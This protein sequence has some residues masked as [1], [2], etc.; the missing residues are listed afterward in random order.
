MQLDSIS[1]TRLLNKWGALSGSRTVSGA[2]SNLPFWSRLN[3]LTPLKPVDAL[4]FVTFSKFKMV[5]E[6]TKLLQIR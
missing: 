2:A 3:G 5:N 6:L 1:N 4:E